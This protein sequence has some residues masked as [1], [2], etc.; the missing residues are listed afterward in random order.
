MAITNS[1]IEKLKELLKQEE[2]KE[3][4]R[5]KQEQENKIKQEKIN[6]HNAYLAIKKE[7]EEDPN[8]RMKL[9]GFLTNNMKEENLIAAIFLCLEN[10]EIKND[11]PTNQSNDLE[12]IGL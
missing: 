5:I 4:L 8:F 12:K 9:T 7:C 2:K 11:T 6:A 10:Q 3:K 1:K